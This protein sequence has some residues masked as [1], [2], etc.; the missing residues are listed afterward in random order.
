M[1]AAGTFCSPVAWT[2]RPWNLIGA[3][4]RALGVGRRR[5]RTRGTPTDAFS[6]TFSWRT[7]GR[8]GAT[9]SAGDAQGA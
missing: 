5:F 1:D 2:L 7:D 6:N 8:A 3:D 9:R 4:L